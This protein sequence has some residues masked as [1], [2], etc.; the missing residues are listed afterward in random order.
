MSTRSEGVIAYNCERFD[1]C[2]EPAADQLLLDDRHL[3]PRLP[4]PS[5]GHAGAH[6]RFTARTNADM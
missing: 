2:V 3:Q 4:E 1:L 5:G 6:L